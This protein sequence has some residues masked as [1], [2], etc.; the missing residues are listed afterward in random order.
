MVG[1]SSDR[2]MVC[3]PVVLAVEGE[4]GGEA[5]AKPGNLQFGVVLS[6]PEI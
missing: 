3:L 4:F 6:L 2:D 1:I 5:S